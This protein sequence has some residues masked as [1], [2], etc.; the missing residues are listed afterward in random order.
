MLY[1]TMNRLGQSGKTTVARYVLTPRLKGSMM[2][3][4]ES[5]TVDGKEGLNIRALGDRRGI[6]TLGAALAGVGAGTHVL[7]I[8]NADTDAALPALLDHANRHPVHVVVPVRASAKAATASLALLDDLTGRQG[9]TITLI[10]NHLEDADSPTKNSGFVDLGK[11]AAARGA[12]L[13]SVGL[14]ENDW[15]TGHGGIK[16]AEEIEKAAKTD[17]SSLDKACAAALCKADLAELGKLGQQRARIDLARAA[18]ANA[19]AVFDAI[20]AREGEGGN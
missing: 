10:G 4:V 1:M 12:A 3:S 20:L 8:G 13:L 18:I 9:V 2:L 5:S 6:Q 19:Q 14:V 17:T 16:T 7:D 15:F 11:E